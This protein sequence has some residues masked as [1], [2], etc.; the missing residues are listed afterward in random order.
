METAK[1]GEVKYVDVC[2]G[3]AVVRHIPEFFQDAR[4]SECA[5]AVRPQI[6][7]WLDN[8]GAGLWFW[9][10]STCGK[11]RAACAVVR[12]LSRRGMDGAGVTGLDLCP[13]LIDRRMGLLS[14]GAESLRMTRRRDYAPELVIEGLI[15][16]TVLLLDDLSLLF[17]L[18]PLA[19]DLRPVFEARIA[20]G[21]PTIVTSNLSRRDYARFCDG[22]ACSYLWDFTCIRFP[23]GAPMPAEIVTRMC[24]DLVGKW[25]WMVRFGWLP[26]SSVGS[27]AGRIDRIK[28]EQTI[29]AGN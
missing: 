10:Q 7:R 23:P 3:D 20:A 27:L 28:Q 15:Q 4:V 1:F 12:E 18:W 17:W 2:A 9:G 22:E 26:A 29:S 14:K 19:A 24:S 16:P 25:E 11:S 21:K 13:V 6:E 8:P 5:D